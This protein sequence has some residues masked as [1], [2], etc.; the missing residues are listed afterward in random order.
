MNTEQDEFRFNFELKQKKDKV[1]LEHKISND[2]YNRIV[3]VFW[4][5][6]QA[7]PYVCWYCNKEGSSLFW[8]HYFTTIE[9]AKKSYDERE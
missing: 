1:L 8:G 4:K 6:N 3:L 5:T 2:G 7:T 9:E